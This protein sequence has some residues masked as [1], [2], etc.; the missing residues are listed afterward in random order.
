MDKKS[1]AEQ[2]ATLKQYTKYC[3]KS[4]SR[5]ERGVFVASRALARKHR[6]LTTE[7][8]PGKQSMGI[9]GATEL[10]Y[11]LSKYIN[12]HYPDQWDALTEK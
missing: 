10:L 3:K 9:Y 1:L 7:I 12:K 5:H 11:V 6:K 8:A 2:S 4:K